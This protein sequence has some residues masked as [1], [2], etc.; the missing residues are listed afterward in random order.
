MF[1]QHRI[2]RALNQN[3]SLYPPLQTCQSDQKQAQNT[4]VGDFYEMLPEIRKQAIFPVKRKK[5][6]L[7]SHLRAE[8]DLQPKIPGK[9]KWRLNARGRR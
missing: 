2:R 9:F 1:R 8:M 6:D 7:R 4:G 3:L 5:A